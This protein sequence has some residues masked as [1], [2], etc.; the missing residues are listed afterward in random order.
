MH[1]YVIMRL[2]PVK[3]KYLTKAQTDELYEKQNGQ[4]AYFRAHLGCTTVG[5]R[6]TVDNMQR[7]HIVPLEHGGSNEIGNF[8]LL[9][10]NCHHAKTR[11]QLISRRADPD[12]EMRSAERRRRVASAWKDV[13][14]YLMG[15]STHP[16]P[17]DA[18]KAYCSQ[19]EER[20]YVDVI[21][22]YTAFKRYFDS[23][24]G[25]L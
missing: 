11:S 18:Y 7:D 21:P 23:L 13:Y 24:A 8:Q 16:T 14:A 3:R 10:A 20:G 15:G 19:C 1:D 22:S 9:C 5:G 2:K 17:Q 6:L 25:R 12:V 4:C